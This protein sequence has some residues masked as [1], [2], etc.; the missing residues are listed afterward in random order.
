MTNNFLL[1]I[2][3]LISLLLLSIFRFDQKKEEKKRT[4]S[5]NFVGEYVDCK[6]YPFL[7]IDKVEK[8]EYQPYFR[9][10]TRG[11]NEIARYRNYR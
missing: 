8:W 9:E 6:R 2:L 3:I 4:K 5:E 1:F 10:Q 11:V 7:C